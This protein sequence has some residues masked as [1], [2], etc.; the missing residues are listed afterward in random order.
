MAGGA[1]D[2]GASRDQDPPV[3][4]ITKGAIKN[5]P[6]EREYEHVGRKLCAQKTFIKRK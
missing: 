5:K 1:P 4:R 3:D 2:W 6:S